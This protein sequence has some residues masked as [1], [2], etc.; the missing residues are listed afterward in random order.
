M[1]ATCRFLHHRNK[2]AAIRGVL[3]DLS[4]SR[5]EVQEAL[6]DLGDV[7]LQCATAGESETRNLCFKLGIVKAV[8]G[9]LRSCHRPDMLSSAARC[10]ALL[11]HGNDEARMELGERGAIGILLHL[12]T[13]KPGTPPPPWPEEWVPVCEQ[14]LV[15]L[16]K[17]TYHCSN[18]QQELARLGGI[19]LIVDLAMDGNILSNYDRY[20]PEMR[21]HLQE[22]VLRKRFM[23][24]V[25]PVPQRGERRGAILRHFPALRSCGE[26]DVSMHYPVFEVDLISRDKEWVSLQLIRKSLAWPDSAPLPEGARWT[27]V[28]VQEVEEG[29]CF[30]CQFCLDRPSEAISHM[31]TSLAN[32]VCSEFEC[33]EQA[34]DVN[35]CNNC[36]RFV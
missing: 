31:N 11:S 36:V 6:S 35:T 25:A 2:L 12:L 21:R 14:A 33:D 8:L 27:C 3:R 17:L 19:K 24:R 29:C 22:L 30:W 16:T 32:L 34:C 5:E 18:N 10:L 26:S 1:M 13:P 23:S 20:P 28:E 4:R 15:C 7:L 9:V